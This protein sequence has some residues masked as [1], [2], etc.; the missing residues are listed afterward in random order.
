MYTDADIMNAKYIQKERA[1][2]KTLRGLFTVVRF[3]KHE[4][5]FYFLKN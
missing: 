1:L 3:S 4:N 5:G 2:V